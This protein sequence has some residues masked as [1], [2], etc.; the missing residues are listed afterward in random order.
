MALVLTIGPHWG[1]V[2]TNG[3]DGG[4]PHD[5]SCA[6]RGFGDRP[7]LL[8][9]VHRDMD[10]SGDKACAPGD[11]TRCNRPLVPCSSCEV[12]VTHVVLSCTFSISQ[13]YFIS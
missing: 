5:G 8:G 13:Q 3:E 7:R 2:D 4:A 9:A 1:D 10:N 6:P 11:V 12:N